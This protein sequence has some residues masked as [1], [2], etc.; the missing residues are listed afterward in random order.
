MPNSKQ[1]LQLYSDHRSLI[2]QHSCEAMNAPRKEAFSLLQTK[3]LP[4][5]RNERYRYFDVQG[6]FAPDYGVNLQRALPSVNPYETYRCNVP[7]LSTAL[8]FV[9]NDTPILNEHSTTQAEGVC[10]KAMS[11]GGE[12]LK[13][14]YNTAVTDNDTVVA[15][16][17]LLAQDGVIIHIPAHTKLK[18]PIQLVNVCDAAFP[19]LS[20]RRI[21]VVAEEGAEAQILICDHVAGKQAYLTTQVTEVFAQQGAKVDIYNIEE[22]AD[23]VNKFAHFYIQQ[24]ADSKV[25]M[26]G[27]NLHAG[28]THNHVNVQL[29]GPRANNYTG[30]AVIAG[31]KEMVDYNVVVEHVSEQCN[32]DMLYKYV[33]DEESIGAFAGKVLVREGAQQT[34]SQQTNANLCVTP[35]AH[36]YAQPMLEIYADDVKCNHGSTVGKLDETALFYMRQRGIPEAEAR[37]LLQHAFVNEVLQQV[38]LEHLRDRLAHLVELRFRGELN[39]CEGC[40]MCK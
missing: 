18:H 11:E 35:T 21:L 3:G 39:K 9:V 13:Q 8:Y 27:V 33:L 2:E 37:L 4:T 34:T 26:N 32:S 19:M 16:N 29:L 23:N 25:T 6:A 30:A 20:S 5:K 10:V 31:G 14:Y 22:N 40:K 36:A 15:I 38:E 17:T 1:Y 28:K 7:N 24:Q 12:L